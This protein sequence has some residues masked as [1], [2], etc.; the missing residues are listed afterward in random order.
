MSKRMKFRLFDYLRDVSL[1]LAVYLPMKGYNFFWLFF[2]AGLS[3][4]LGFTV[5][6]INPRKYSL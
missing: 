4:L 5:D 3:G 6:L 1:V 2:F